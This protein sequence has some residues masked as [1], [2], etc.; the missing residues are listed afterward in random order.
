MMDTNLILLDVRE[1]IEWE[2]GYVPGATLISLSEI[3]IR[4]TELDKQKPVA[5]ICEAGIRSS[6]AASIL[7]RVGFEQ[8][9]NVIEGTAGYRS[10]ALPLN[11]K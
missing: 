8:V 11:Y 7:Q 9:S 10:K 3:G 4:N 5:V 6:T 1:Q 2:M